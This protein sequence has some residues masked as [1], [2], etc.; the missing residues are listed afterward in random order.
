MAVNV[1]KVIVGPNVW[2]YTSGEFDLQTASEVWKAIPMKRT[3]LTYELK[4]TNLTLTTPADLEPFNS[5]KYNVPILPIKV[6]VYEYPAMSVRFMGVVTGI[7]YIVNKNIA[8]VK[9][10]STDTIGKTM[11]PNRTYGQQC[12][13]DLFDELCGLDKNNFTL[14]L[15]VSELVWESDNIFS[16]PDLGNYQEGA[17]SMGYVLLNTGESQYIVEHTGEKIQLLDTLYTLNKATTIDV[18][19]GC[20]KSLTQCRDK[21]N[22]TPNFGGFPFIPTKNPSTEGF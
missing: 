7:K 8:E 13:F 4:Q 5:F 16:H 2:L 3:D 15:Q 18:V 20:N 11:C 10:G 6:E 9:L 1:Y 22:N 12:S 14:T 21:F 17:F 19:F